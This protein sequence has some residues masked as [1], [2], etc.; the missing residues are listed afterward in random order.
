[1]TAMPVAQPL[2]RIEELAPLSVEQY[3]RMVAEGILAEG[4]PI[5]LLEGLLVRRDEGVEMT[6]LPRHASILDR[7]VASLVPRLAGRGCY[8]R[9]QNPLT[10]PPFDEPEPDAAIVAG[11]PAE[12]VDRHPQANDVACVI[13]ISAS[14]LERDR[15]VKSRIYATAGIPQYVILNL[16]DSVIEVFGQPDREKGANRWMASAVK[17]DR[18]ALRLPGD[19]YLDI[20]V[21]ELLP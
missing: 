3:H 2:L 18:L 1:M 8:L 12:F 4:E 7:L 9:A 16:V 5:E 21:D 19:A 20:A 17:G 11:S 6:I 10:L 14:S 13:E 15:T